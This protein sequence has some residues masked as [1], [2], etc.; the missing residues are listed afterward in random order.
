MFSLDAW[1][2][3]VVTLWYLKPFRVKSTSMEDLTTIN[4]H[5]MSTSRKPYNTRVKPKYC[6]FPV[7]GLPWEITPC[8]T[9][10]IVRQSR[11]LVGAHLRLIEMNVTSKTTLRFS[12][13][14]PNAFLFFL[15]RGKVSFC[16]EHGQLLNEVQS[17]TYYLT[18][19]PSG[20][21][22]AEMEKGE[23]SMLIIGLDSDWFMSSERNNY[24]AFN[25]MLEM[26]TTNL[27]TPILLPQKEIT[28]E[29]WK[30]L[31]QIR[32]AIVENIDDGLRVLKCISKCMHIY[33]EQLVDPK[34]LNKCEDLLKG[35]ILKEHLSTCYMFEE[36]CRM[37]TILKKLGWP[38]WTLRTVANNTF[39]CSVGRYV[40]KLR[41]DKAMDLLV[42]TDMLIREIAVR[43]GFSSAMS[44]IRAF[45]KQM[46]ISPNEYRNRKR[47][48]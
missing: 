9:C 2:T 17:P 26:P 33:H 25:P 32:M 37:E 39:G 10:E 47:D 23:H 13:K 6:A 16:N 27:H 46:G 20:K 8:E 14:R 35:E 3:I 48:D 18:Y 44:F 15:L 28:A 4:I 40:S 7:V 21:F 31:A 38:E 19:G 34:E 5:E 24:P 11:S 41:M 1:I 42:S 29:V 12:V 30:T 43:I 45:K 36:E 22:I